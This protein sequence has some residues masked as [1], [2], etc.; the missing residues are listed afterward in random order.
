M[1]IGNVCKYEHPVISCRDIGEAYY[2]LHVGGRRVPFLSA[3]AVDQHYIRRYCRMVY[4]TAVS[5]DGYESP[6]SE[7]FRVCSK[8]E[9]I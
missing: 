3:I 9:S 8:G 6:P 4:V 2:I 7:P 1:T 5:E